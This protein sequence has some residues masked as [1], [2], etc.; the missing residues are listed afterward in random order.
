MKKNMCFIVGC[1]MAVLLSLGSCGQKGETQELKL[2]S[3]EYP[4]NEIFGNL[5]GLRYQQYRNDSII[6]AWY[7]ERIDELVVEMTGKEAE[8]IRQ[9]YDEL[10]KK[11]DEDVNK[12]YDNYAALYEIEDKRISGNEIPFE[13][14]E[15][16]GYI[17]DHL[18]VNSISDEGFITLGCGISNVDSKLTEGNTIPVLHC[19]SLDSKGNVIEYFAFAS[20]VTL[21]LENRRIQYSTPLI[22]HEK[23]AY[24]FFDFAK[25]RFFKK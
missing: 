3:K 2:E 5:F 8:Q 10:L 25:V 24:K 17:V 4:K 6:K 13:M 16:L 15:E 12:Q 9:Q 7:S 21:D 19:E 11:R 14:E 20:F 18:F 22:F 1:A 23:D